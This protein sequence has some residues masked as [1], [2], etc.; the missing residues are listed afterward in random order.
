MSEGEVEGVKG[1]VEGGSVRM[2]WRKGGSGGGG[3]RE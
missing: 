3:G 2:E 1:E